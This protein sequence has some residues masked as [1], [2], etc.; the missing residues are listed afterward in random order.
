MS[1]RFPDVFGLGRNAAMNSGCSQGPLD[2][3]QNL[4][5][6]AL[7]GEGSRGSFLNKFDV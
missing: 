6:A 4:T 3:G 5:R 7:P 1:L 2:A